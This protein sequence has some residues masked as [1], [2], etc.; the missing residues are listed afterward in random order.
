[1]SIKDYKQ[2][3]QDGWSAFSRAAK[4][5]LPEPY[6]VELVFDDGSKTSKIKVPILPGKSESY[7]NTGSGLVKIVGFI[8]Y[9]SDGKVHNMG[10]MAMS[11]TLSPYD[12]I[13]MEFEPGRGC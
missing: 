1:M 9:K 12:S 8:V 13:V 2:G 11:R 6:Y 10:M 3:W 7:A 5:E 4:V